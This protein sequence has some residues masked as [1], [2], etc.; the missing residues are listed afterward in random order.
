MDAPFSDR[1]K[2]WT[3]S[4]LG[5]GC[6]PLRTEKTKNLRHGRF[7]YG[8][9]ST[10]DV[11]MFGPWMPLLRTDYLIMLEPWMRLLRTD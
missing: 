8:T 11:S 4:C 1:V 9:D 2:P 6:P 3:L 10:V 5:H 7:I